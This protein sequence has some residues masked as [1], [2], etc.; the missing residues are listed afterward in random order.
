M[1]FPMPQVH[2]G[3]GRSPY[4]AMFGCTPRVG[5]PSPQLPPAVAAVLHTEEQ[6]QETLSTPSTSSARFCERCLAPVQDGDQCPCESRPSRAAEHR[7]AARGRQQQQAQRML[8]RSRNSME[9]VAVGDSVRVGIPDVDRSRVENRNLI[10][11]VLQV[12]LR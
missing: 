11:V 1:L 6:L 10:C 9:E 12:I 3:I 7:E 4:Q 5:L 2:Q 8:K